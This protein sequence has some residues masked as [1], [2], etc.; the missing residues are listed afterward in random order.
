ML[1]NESLLHLLSVLNG[2]FFRPATTPDRVIRDVRSVED[3]PD[4]AGMAVTVVAHVFAPEFDA[5]DCGLPSGFSE[6]VGEFDCPAFRVVEV[7]FGLRAA[8]RGVG[9]FVVARIQSIC[10]LLLLRRRLRCLRSSKCRRSPGV[11][12]VPPGLGLSPRGLVASRV[13]C[14][15]ALA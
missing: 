14:L 1:L 15:L 12:L 3:G 13:F 5:P 2:C 10:I 7:F 8:G 9:Y 11:G 6:R 4:S